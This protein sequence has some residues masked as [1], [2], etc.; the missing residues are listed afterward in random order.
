MG[1]IDGLNQIMRILRRQLSEKTQRKS[2]NTATNSLFSS[3]AAENKTKPSLQALQQKIHN[4][5]DAL[6]ETEKKGPKAVSIFIESILLWEF[7]DALIEDNQ[8]TE[9]AERLQHIMTKDPLTHNK[10]KTFL[11]SL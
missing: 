4:R 10:I 5:I 11:N 8:F 1:P 2:K 3:Y 9:L 6:E 7:G